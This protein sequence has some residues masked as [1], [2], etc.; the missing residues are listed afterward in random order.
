MD[1]S[2]L[3]AAVGSN[4]ADPIRI[5]LLFIAALERKPD[6]DIWGKVY[7]AVAEHPPSRRTTGPSVIEIPN[8]SRLV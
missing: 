5:K 2:A 6:A 4:D 7:K 1:I 8:A 3:S